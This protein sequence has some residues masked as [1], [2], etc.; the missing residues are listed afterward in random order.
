MCFSHVIDLSVPGKCVRFNVIEKFISFHNTE[1][2]IFFCLTEC[3]RSDFLINE[4]CY[5]KATN[6]CLCIHKTYMNLPFGTKKKTSSNI[7]TSKAHHLWSALNNRTTIVCITL[8]CFTSNVIF[9]SYLP[10]TSHH[11]RLLSDGSP[12]RHNTFYGNKKYTHTH[13]QPIILCA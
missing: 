7:T 6:K 8:S 5:V 11:R 9:I 12:V 2:E 4:H 10:L 13:T 1:K 3:R